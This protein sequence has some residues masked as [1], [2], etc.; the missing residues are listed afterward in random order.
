MTEQPPYPGWWK[1]SDGNWYPPQQRPAQPATA[2]SGWWQAS[3]GKWYPPDQHPGRQAQAPQSPKAPLAAPQQVSEPAVPPVPPLAVQPEPIPVVQ[4]SAVP[5]APAVPPATQP[6]PSPTAGWWQASDGRWYP[7]QP[8]APAVVD[9]VV[10]VATTPAGY[11]QQ[12]GSPQPTAFPAPVRSTAPPHKPPTGRGVT[13][14]AALIAAMVVVAGVFFVSS[15]DGNSGDEVD[16]SPPVTIDEGIE[17]PKERDAEEENS[18]TEEEFELEE[19]VLGG[20]SSDIEESSPP[21]TESFDASFPG[22]SDPVEVE[23]DSGEAWNAASAKA[24]GNI[25]D[26]WRRE[27]PE[28]FGDEYEPISGGFYAYSSNEPV[29]PCASSRQEVANNAYYC[30]TADVVAWDDEVLFPG[31]YEQAGE[32][33]VGLILAHEIGHAV[34][35]RVDFEGRTI[36]FENQADC[37]AGAWI[38]SVA[39][40]PNDEFPVTSGDLDR[41]LAQ[42]VQIADTPGTAATDPFAHG[43]AFDRVNGFRDGLD[44]GAAK[45]AGYTDQN[46]VTTQV[47]FGSVGEQLSG[48]NLPYLTNDPDDDI[49][50]LMPEDLE[51]FWAAEFERRFGEWDPIDGSVITYTSGDSLPCGENEID[52]LAFYCAT[53]DYIGIET[54][55]AVRQLYDEFGDFGPGIV[56][57]AQYGFAIESRLGATEDRLLNSL[58]ADCYAG[59]WTASI[60]PT[61]D[62]P[63]D[64]TET[65]PQRRILSISPGDLDEAVETLLILGDESDSDDNRGTGFERVGAFREGVLNGFEGCSRFDA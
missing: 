8:S 65:D 45:C 47:P 61:S 43:N 27:F 35:E 33:G 10:P 37:Y 25:E 24:L 44:N 3:D 46:I 6:E 49:F 34:Q 1:A 5:P 7:P 36:T 63:F 28:I 48:G 50:D 57:A 54:E 52:L 30:G 17:A 41:A 40:N 58:Q 31:V 16:V 26:F 13:L 11:V 39:E 21:T 59:V 18:A 62:R 29:P 56:M 2:D 38:A 60:L 19:G 32:L 23:G 55:T 42:F 9:P 12:P 14:A 51:L 15:R 53:N 22:P 64:N 4:P 20:E